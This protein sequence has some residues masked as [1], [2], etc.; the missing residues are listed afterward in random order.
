ME[1][2]PEA[3]RKHAGRILGTQSGAR[4]GPLR[5]DAFVV[6]GGGME[7]PLLV[8]SLRQEMIENGYFE[9]S[10]YGENDMTVDEICK[11]VDLPH[12]TIR[13]STVG[14]LRQ[15]GFD[16]FRCPPPPLHLCVRFDHEPTDTVLE[17]LRG[18]FDDSLPNPHRR[19]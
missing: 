1:L 18:A 6:R 7:I 4:R 8:V 14:A 13:V 16:P 2:P 15:A 5:D 17:R 11:E 10:F 19:R 12:G 3:S 9:L